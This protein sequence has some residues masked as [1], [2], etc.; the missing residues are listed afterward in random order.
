MKTMNKL[1][2]QVLRESF[3]CTLCGERIPST[4]IMDDDDGQP[5]CKDCFKILE[6]ESKGNWE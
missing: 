2:E 5:F 3:I 6:A 4:E 1:F